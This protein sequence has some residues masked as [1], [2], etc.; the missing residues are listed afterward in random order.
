M[1][2][3][4]AWCLKADEPVFLS[5]QLPHRDACI[6]HGICPRHRGTWTQQLVAHV[7]ARQEEPAP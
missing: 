4:C 6:S 1:S 3:L 2:V 5:E 7:K